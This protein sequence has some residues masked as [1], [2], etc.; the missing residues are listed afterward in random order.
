MNENLKN[1][2]KFYY[3]NLFILK[4]IN[5]MDEIEERVE[6]DKIAKLRLDDLKDVCKDCD[7]TLC[8][9]LMSGFSHSEDLIK[10]TSLTLED[11]NENNTPI[12]F[13]CE[14][15]GKDYF[16]N[17]EKYFGKHISFDSLNYWF[18]KKSDFK[19]KDNSKKNLDFFSNS[20]NDAYAYSFAHLI[21]K[22]NLSNVYITNSIKCKPS[23]HS[24]FNKVK[25]ELNNN[26]LNK[27]L[28]E[29]I[30]LIKPQ[31]IFCFG[32]NAYRNYI[33]IENKDQNIKVVKILHPSIRGKTISKYKKLYSND[34]IFT[35]STLKNIKMKILQT[36]W[37]NNFNKQ[38]I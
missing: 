9:N 8:C 14:N 33:Q 20:S 34:P 1:L 23:K 12:I 29:E 24:N 19:R 15:P 30:S 17:S 38:F 35:N 18:S 32:E 5:K 3:Q 31:I 16:N 10:N 21:V 36:N 22:Y 4:D 11:K 6:G 7:K 25:P 13:L 37:Y 26:C 2:K 28:K 27:F